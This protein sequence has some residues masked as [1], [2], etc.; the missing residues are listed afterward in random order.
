MGSLNF[1]T[2]DRFKASSSSSAGDDLA[3]VYAVEQV[4]KK[5]AAAKIRLVLEKLKLM[6]LYI[7]FRMELEISAWL[8]NVL[9]QL[10]EIGEDLMEEVGITAN[11][12]LMQAR[13]NMEGFVQDMDIK[14]IPRALK[15]S[16]FGFICHG[17]LLPSSFTL[18]LVTKIAD[19]TVGTK[20][21]FAVEAEGFISPFVKKSLDWSV[22]TETDEPVPCQESAGS[23]GGNNK[24]GRA[25]V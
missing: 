15:S 17:N 6:E 5:L 9:F 19:I 3:Q 1:N 4:E 16:E 11:Q 12:L 8:E 20:L 22:H 2:N 7:L 14:F 21:T 24:I 25:H 23:A 18:E 10:T 13:E